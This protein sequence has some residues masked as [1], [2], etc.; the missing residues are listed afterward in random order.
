MDGSQS[1]DVRITSRP[2]FHH[3]DFTEG[4]YRDLLRAAL[5]WYRFAAFTEFDQAGEL[6]LWRHDVEFSP[7]RARRLASIEGELRIVRDVFAIGHRLGLHFARASLQHPPRQ[8]AFQSPCAVDDCRKENRKV[9][10]LPTRFSR[11]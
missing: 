1:R 2:Q 4:H 6:C 11:R 8:D 9:A 7:Q 3:A 10:C 5:K